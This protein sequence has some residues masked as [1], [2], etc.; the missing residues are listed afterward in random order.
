MN[1]THWNCE[2]TILP[3]L[4]RYLCFYVHSSTVYNGQEIEAGSHAVWVDEQNHRHTLSHTH[5]HTCAHTYIYMYTL[6][7]TY[8]NVHTMHIHIHAHIH[9]PFSLNLANVVLKQHSKTSNNNAQVIHTDTFL[10]LSEFP[11]E[12]C[13]SWS[14]LSGSQHIFQSLVISSLFEEILILFS[15]SFL[16]SWN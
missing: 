7:H 2:K 6:I 4:K 11:K 12:Y 15:P 1:F 10:E 13:L 3:N 9:P 5:I 8:T 14:L 16:I